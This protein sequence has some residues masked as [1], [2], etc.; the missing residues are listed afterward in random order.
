MSSIEKSTLLKDKNLYVIFGI[1][2]VS[3]M[4]VSSIAPALPS[5]A[6]TLSVTNDQI[7]LLITFY[8]LPG[9][10]LTPILGIIAD[11]YGRKRVLI[12]SLFFFGI[13]GTACAFATSFEQLLLFRALQGMGSDS[14]GALNLTLI[15]DL[16]SG[17][18]NGC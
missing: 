3:V 7:G 15:G 16:Y 13:A 6:R 11:R 1:T 12:P 4:G 2:L 10:I 5:I 8:T 18:N 14:L 9:I 17:K